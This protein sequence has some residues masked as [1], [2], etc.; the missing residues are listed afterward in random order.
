MERK[1]ENGLIAM[2][3]TDCTFHPF[4]EIEIANSPICNFSP[5]YTD[6]ISNL[7]CQTLD[8]L[9]SGAIGGSTGA[10]AG[11]RS[12]RG[13]PA[14]GVATGEGRGAPV[15]VGGRSIREGGDLTLIDRQVIVIAE[16]IV[17]V[18]VTLVQI[19]FSSR[20]TA[21]KLKSELRV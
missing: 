12:G 11:S 8:W 17:A 14:H 9:R 20:R 2:K 1:S 6:S 5:V 21:A 16:A 15:E 13:S 10:T 3:V 7:I 4:R 19:L 18:S